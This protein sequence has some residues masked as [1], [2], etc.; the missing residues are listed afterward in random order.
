M[1]INN[2]YKHFTLRNGNQILGNK[3]YVLEKVANPFMHI[4]EK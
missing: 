2:L 3:H 1:V 4:V